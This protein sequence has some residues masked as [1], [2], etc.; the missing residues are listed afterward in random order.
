MPSATFKKIALICDML[1]LVLDPTIF[2]VAL[3]Y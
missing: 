1:I 3:F 2:G